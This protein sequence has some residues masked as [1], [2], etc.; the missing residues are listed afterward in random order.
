MFDLSGATPQRSERLRL[1]REIYPEQEWQRSSD[2]RRRAEGSPEPSSSEGW[3]RR[4]SAE[5]VPASSCPPAARCWCGSAPVTRADDDD[6]EAGRLPR[7]DGLR[8]PFGPPP[9]LPCVCC[10][11][12]CISASLNEPGTSTLGRRSLLSSNSFGF[13]KLQHRAKVHVHCS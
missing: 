9:P 12:A 4:A 8:S 3:S 2:R 5:L 11:T 13:W 1:I 6:G 10:A 7:E